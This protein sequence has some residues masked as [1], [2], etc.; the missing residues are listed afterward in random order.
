MARKPKSAVENEKKG[1]SSTT[2]KTKTNS[3][4][5]TTQSSVI[6]TLKKIWEKF[7]VSFKDGAQKLQNCGAAFVW[8]TVALFIIMGVAAVA[9][10]LGINKG[11]E[12]VMVPDVVGTNLIRAQLILQEKELYPRL[13]MR[14]SD[15][16]GQAG[17]IISQSPKKGAVVKAQSRVTLVVSRGVVF[18]HVGNYVGT[19]LDALKTTLDALY[20][21]AEIPSLT[22]ANPIFKQD[23]SL[24]GTILQQDPPEGTPITQPIELKFIVSSGPQK[25]KVPVPDLT[26]KNINEVLATMSVTKLTFDFSAHIAS[27]NE[28][29]GTVVKQTTPGNKK[30]IGEYS[31]IHLEFAMPAVTEESDEVPQSIDISNKNEAEATDAALVRDTTNYVH[32]IFSTRIPEYPYAVPVK[33]DVIPQEG[34][35][36]GIATFNHIGGDLTIPY[37]V[38][39]G[40]VLVL[41]VLER[42]VERTSIQ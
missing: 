9:I 17:Q 35:R 16:P 38:P 28:K 27:G 4:K 8:Y 1:I 3:A 15:V 12:R 2:K 40:S 36:Y 20:A 34:T 26:G 24:P 11:Y 42:E 10:F 14:Y 18:D 30:E 13:Q 32:G 41:S 25:M 23:G 29:P 7:G 6:K 5:N 22:I 39:H 21:G 33:L 19:N 31:H 37:A